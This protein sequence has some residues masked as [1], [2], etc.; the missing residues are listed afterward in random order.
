MNNLEY[1]NDDMIGFRK[2]TRTPV[3]HSKEQDTC[4]SKENC[5]RKTNQHNDERDRKRDNN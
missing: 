3:D 5:K 2:A 4:I 1:L